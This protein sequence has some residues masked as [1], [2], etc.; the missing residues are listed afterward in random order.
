[1][2]QYRFP[3][4]VRELENM[5]KRMIALGDV[6]GSEPAVHSP[7][8]LDARAPLPVRDDRPDGVSLKDISRKAA[9]QAERE[10]IVKML[11]HTRWNRVKAAKLLNISYRSLLYKIKDAGLDQRSSIGG[12]S[13]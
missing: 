13:T 5:V 4:N 9:Q 2:L 3:G 6:D 10:Q 7:A 12:L 8:H 11:E 1:M